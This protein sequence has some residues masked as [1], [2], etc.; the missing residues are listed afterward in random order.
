[1]N[2]DKVEIFDV[3]VATNE[4]FP[5]PQRE[6][7]IAGDLPSVKDKSFWHDSPHVLESLERVEQRR[8]ALI[9]QIDGKH[10]VKLRGREFICVSCPFEH[11]IPVDADKYTLD[12]NGKIVPIDVKVKHNVT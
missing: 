9:S 5:E 4:D 11:T 8:Q 1:M 3:G 12:N 7:R 2:E 10:E 6:R